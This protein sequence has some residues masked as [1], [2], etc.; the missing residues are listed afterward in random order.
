M[1]K[2]PLIL[3]LRGQ[4]KVGSVEEAALTTAEVIKL[5]KAGQF[6]LVKW[7][8]NSRTVLNTIPLSHRLS[9]IK[10]FDD[11]DTHKVLSLCWSPESDVFSLKVNPPAE[12][13]TKRTMLSC[14]ARLWDVMSFV[15]PVVLYTKLFIKQ[16]WLCECDWDDPP[17]DSIVQ[18]W[19]RLR[20]E[21]PLLS[22]IKIPRHIN[23]DRN[24]VIT[25]VGFADASEK[26]YGGVVYFHVQNNGRN[27]ISLISSKSRVSPR[28]IVSLARLDLCAI[29]VLAKLITAVISACSDRVHIDRIFAF[30]D[31]SV[32][33]C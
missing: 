31:T 17:P 26:A 22:E 19:L 30:S 25:I 13:C 24:S 15:A 16:L 14:V 28:K 32:A 8:S 5:M 9:A 21:L 11:S 33:L 6:D 27:S 7:T 2:V 29:L 12:T 18:S 20:E 3:K 10:E 23:V 4:L 1:M